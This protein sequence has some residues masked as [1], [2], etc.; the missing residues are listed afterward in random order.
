M[1]EGT[2]TWGEGTTWYAV[3]GDGEEP[4]RLPLLCLHGGPGALHDYL[5]PLADLAATGRRVVFYDQIG[6]GRS[7]HFDDPSRPS[8]ALYVDELAAVR[9]ALGLDRCHLLGQSWGGM[10]AMEAVLRGATGIA[11]LVLADSPASMP[12]WVAETG[13]LRSALPADVQ[14]TLARHEAAGTTDD[15]EYEAAVSVFY[16]RHLCRVDPYPECLVR[17]F[18]ALAKDPL[19]Y[20]T[21]NGPSEFHVTGTLRAWDVTPR[22]GEIRVPTLVLSGAFDEATPAV[23]G[24]VHRGIAGSEWVVFPASSHMPHLE[25]PE[26]YR[27]AVTRFLD[28]VEAAG[29][30]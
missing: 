13:R 30:R 12:L 14:E 11:S 28:R 4:G 20:R 17:S 8:V 21:M 1:R 24:A 27:A 3:H 29:G 22:L 16:R 18:E 23:A 19:V 6:C 5:D 10:L 15:P 2:I 9:A 25:E 26:A 7:G